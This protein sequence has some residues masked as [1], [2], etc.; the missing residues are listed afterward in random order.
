MVEVKRLD[1]LIAACAELQSSGVDFD[2]YLAGE[3]PDR[4]ATERLVRESNL[5][6]RIHFIGS[7]RHDELPE[8]YRAADVTVLSSRS[9]GL[10]NVLRESLACGTPFAST[11]VGSIREIADPI[12]SRLAPPGDAPQLARAIRDVLTPSH[13]AAAARYRARTWN[14]C[15]SDVT[16]LFSELKSTHGE[17]AIREG[18]APAEPRGKTIVLPA[19]ASSEHHAQSGGRGSCRAGAPGRSSIHRGSAGASP[20]QHANTANEPSGHQQQL[21]TTGA[22]EKGELHGD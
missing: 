18:E 12:W 13:R 1:I 6:S 15:A 11:D 10:P 7:V 8:W 5:T 14:T 20:S 4:S 21:V 16:R 17:G 2:L 3:G 19:T 9:E 22:G